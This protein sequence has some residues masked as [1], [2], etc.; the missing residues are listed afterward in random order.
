MSNLQY[1]FVQG[2]STTDAIKDLM[3]WHRRNLEKH[4]VAILLDISGAFDNL[5]WQ[6]LHYD[7]EKLGCSLSSR[8]IIKSY[9]SNRT[10]SIKFAGIKKTITLTKGCPQ[11]S[12]FGPVLW[13]SYYERASYHRFSSTR[14]NTGLCRRH[15]D[16]GIC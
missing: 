7:L 11:G 16:L 12:I 3:S 2:K 5:N 10:A 8:E 6:I 9:L 14:E 4:Q 1:G 15:S 13:N